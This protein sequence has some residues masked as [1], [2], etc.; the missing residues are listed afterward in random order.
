MS[1]LVA[2]GAEFSRSTVTWIFFSLLLGCL[3]LLAAHAAHDAQ[4]AA[5]RAVRWIWFSAIGVIVAL[6]LAAPFRQLATQM[7]IARPERSRVTSLSLPRVET[8]GPALA[9]W[10]RSRNAMRIPVEATIQGVQST[11]ASVPAPVQRA[12]AVSWLLATIATLGVF[13]VSYRRIRRQMSRWPKQRVGSVVARIAPA[14]GPAV[15]GLVPAQIILPAWLLDCPAEDQRLVVMH[16]SEHVRAGDPWLLVIACGAVAC[17]LW[18][19]ALWF[20]LGRLRLAIELD[21]DRRVL[22]RGIPAVA[23][24]SLL[25]DLSVM[26]SALPSAMPAFSCNGSYLERRL[27]AM[28]SR[29]SRFAYARR[30]GSGLVATV[31]LITACESKLPTSAEVERMDV[32]SAERAIVGTGSVRYVVDGTPVSEAVAK[33]ISAEHITSVAVTKQRD[34]SSEIRIA[35]KD[36]PPAMTLTSDLKKPPSSVLINL[37]TARPTRDSTGDPVGP[38][39]LRRL[40]DGLLI[41]DGVVTESAAMNRLDQDRIAS[42]EVVKGAAAAKAYSDPRAMNG[43]II[44]TTKPKP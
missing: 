15:V 11:L 36:A 12:L 5:N 20:A 33:A 4:R 26:R 17:M 40:F 29:P 28:T 27:V 23:Y 21:C 18:H 38:S 43:V 25:I 6:S 10:S 30:I 42:I 37:R 16:E 9:W 13:A 1:D 22:R 34:A 14:A 3:V 8:N 35:T 19:P 31:A 24:G 41:V 44:V 32:S 7:R 2:L 39:P